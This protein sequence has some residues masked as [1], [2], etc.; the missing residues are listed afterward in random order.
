MARAFKRKGKA[1]VARMDQVERQVVVHL[2]EQTRTVLAAP[3]QPSTGDTFAD[4]IAE[5]DPTRGDVDG[6]NSGAEPSG[7]GGSDE[8][9]PAPQR[10]PAL[11]RL[12]PDAHYD[13]P[14]IAAEFRQLTERGLRDRKSANLTA[15]IDA[16]NAAETDTVRLDAEQAQSTV[17]AL[18]D[19]R[20]LLGERLGLHTDEDAQRLPELLDGDR[21]SPVTAMVA[22]YEF[23]TWLQESLSLA[24]L[25]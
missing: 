6:A 23:L 21:Q 18:T 2:L 25:K 5:L 8:Q 10:D 12:L 7:A 3:Y 1:Y 22:Y 11:R 4:L 19:V 24:L 14:E 17:V 13:D 16:L 15:A 20:L 9:A